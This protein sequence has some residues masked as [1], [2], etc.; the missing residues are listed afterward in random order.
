MHIAIIGSGAVGQALGRALSRQGH[1]VTFGSRTAAD[2]SGVTREWTPPVH[3]APPAEA[4]AGADIIILA[5]P[6]KVAEAAI[7]GL[8][9]LA[10][11]IVI[12][13]MNPIAM[14]PDGIG[15]AL[16]HTTSGGEALQGW[17]PEARVVKTLNQVG[18]EVMADTSGFA[19]PPLQFMAG[20]DPDAKETVAQLLA[21]LGFQPLDAGNLAKARLLE[22]LAL[23]WINQSLARGLGRDWAFA[24]LPRTAATA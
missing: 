11:K 2:L 22:P 20:D 6:W 16:G 12:D 21:D 17:L 10:G 3:A 15:L 14:G 19:H 24:A 18:A 1:E 8:G 4:A 13:C 23:T 5:L 7:R 9:P